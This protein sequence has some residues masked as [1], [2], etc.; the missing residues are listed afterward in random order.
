[1]N[2][3][4]LREKRAR[5]CRIRDLRAA[6]LLGVYAALPCRRTLQ[7]LI[8]YQHTNLVTPLVTVCGFH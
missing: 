2:K 1:V 5:T 8:I 6:E 7:N 3:N 4:D